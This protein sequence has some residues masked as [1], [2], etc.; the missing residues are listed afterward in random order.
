MD[1][2]RQA[3]LPMGFFRQE[4]W[5]GLPCPPPGDL[6]YSGT[7]PA[8]LMSPALAG[9]VFKTSATWEAQSIHIHYQLICH[10]VHTASVLSF[11]HCCYLL[12]AV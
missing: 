10:D 2:S 4:Y 9:R 12:L 8:S 7:E 6:P 3:P 11:L 1:G 5:R